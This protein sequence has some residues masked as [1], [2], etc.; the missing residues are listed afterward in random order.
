[1]TLI[2]LFYSYFIF[3]K[4][5]SSLIVDFPLFIS[6]KLVWNQLLKEKGHFH[7]EQDRDKEK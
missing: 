3:T 6:A 7:N 2:I 4:A 1:M 5:F